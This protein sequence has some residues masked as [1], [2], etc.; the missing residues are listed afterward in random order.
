LEA[1]VQAL[2]LEIAQ[3]DKCIVTQ[4]GIVQSAQA[5][6][7]RNAKLLED[8]GNL[9]TACE[10]EYKSSSKA[11]QSELALLAAIQERVEARFG[12]LSQG[13]TQRGTQDTFSYN[14]END[15]ERKE[16]VASS[17]N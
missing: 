10:E 14:A 11:R 8:A 17:G 5:K 3:L 9:C 13:V 2:E 16:F 4:T 15:Y 6:L 7:E 1:A 12:Q